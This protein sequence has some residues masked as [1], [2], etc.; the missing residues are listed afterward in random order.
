MVL[1]ERM[2]LC[3]TYVNTDGDLRFEASS[4]DEGQLSAL[5]GPTYV[6]ERRKCCALLSVVSCIKL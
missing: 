1:V 6:V 5:T 2:A 4:K 3:V